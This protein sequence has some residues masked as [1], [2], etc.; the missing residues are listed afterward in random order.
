MDHAGQS[1]ESA[2]GTQSGAP[3]ESRREF[4]KAGA[5]GL[6]LAMMSGLAQAQPTQ[7]ADA[8]AK[9]AQKGLEF[10]PGAVN[11]QGEFVLPPLPYAYNALEPAMDE[12]TMKLHH[13]KHHAGYVEGLIKAQKGLT[14]ARTSGD[15]ALVDHYLRKI[16]FHG[17][18]HFLHC[19]NWVG[20]SPKGGKPSADLQKA[21]DA[22]F[23]SMEG[24]S[25]LFANA[26]KSVE[27]SGW[28]VLCYSIPTRKL[29]VLQAMNHNF[30]TDW[31]NVPLLVVDVWEHA[32]YK[33]YSN[34]RGGWIKAWMGIVNWQGVSERYDLARQV[35]A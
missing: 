12:L 18:G 6:G 7:A 20:M 4:L 14:E 34:D 16:S 27:G 21:I 24:F 26:A 15:F 13:D 2:L 31:A 5:A 17:G 22:D 3:G 32:Y 10:F 23:G 9:A 8:Q 25:N 11:A 35:F 28:G 1:V 33:Q 30:L 29:G 19:L